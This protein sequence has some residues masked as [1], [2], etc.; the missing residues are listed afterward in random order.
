MKKLILF[1]LL[2]VLSLAG[3]SQ[4]FGRLK[5][6][7]GLYD[8]FVING[9]DTSVFGWRT[10]RFS[11]GTDNTKSLEFLLNGIHSGLIDS[12][13]NKTNM[14]AATHF[15]YKSGITDTAEANS[16]F[17]YFAGNSITSGSHN[18]AMGAFSLASNTTAP[19]N[20]AIGQNAMRYSLTGGWNTAV[21]QAAL[22]NNATGNF[23]TAIGEDVLLRGVTGSYNTGVGSA[24]LIDCSGNNNTSFGSYSGYELTSGSYNLFLGNEAGR[25]GNWNYKGFIDVIDRGDS[26][27]QLTS[28]PIVIDFNA[29]SS[30][31]NVTFNADVYVNDTAFMEHLTVTDSVTLEDAL[32]DIY[33]LA[34]DADSLVVADDG[35]INL[36]AGAY[37]ELHVSVYNAGMYEEFAWAII[38]TDGSIGIL[39]QNSTDVTT[40]GG[41]DNKLNIYDGGTYAIIENKLGGSRTI[42]YWFTH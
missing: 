13:L 3:F 8:N 27:S 10:D 23:N 30:L 35:V 26:A 2:S 7:S 24:S 28:S 5:I 41:T 15:G 42:K 37:G 34:P 14:G 31:Q 12:S 1:T 36:R 21:G 19:Y 40:T 18:V 32:F 17:G 38:N 29:D 20:T 11:L 6:H 25:Y 39:I 16:F 4:N 33:H 22:Q 9:P